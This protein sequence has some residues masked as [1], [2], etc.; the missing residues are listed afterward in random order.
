MTVYE[1]R[2]FHGFR[3]HEHECFGVDEAKCYEV[4]EAKVVKVIKIVN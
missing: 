4:N 2:S 1:V 3:P